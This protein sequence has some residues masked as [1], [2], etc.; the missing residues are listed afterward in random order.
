MPSALERAG[1]TP[2][3]LCYFPRRFDRARLGEGLSLL[4]EAHH[5]RA[6]R[7]DSPFSARDYDGVLFPD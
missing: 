7:L 2:F 1:A 4:Y 5:D 3:Q 6:P